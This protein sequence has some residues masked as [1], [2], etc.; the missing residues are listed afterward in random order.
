MA[1]SIARTRK[2]EIGKRLLGHGRRSQAIDEFAIPGTS[3][4]AV[5]SCV[6]ALAV[7]IIQDFTWP[8]PTGGFLTIVQAAR[9]VRD[10]CS[11]RLSY[12]CLP[13]GAL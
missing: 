6:C 10:A 12:F 3:G 2:L 9:S 7:A 5:V 4:R 13:G 11:L 1:Q 8:P